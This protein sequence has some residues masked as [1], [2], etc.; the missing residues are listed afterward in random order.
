MELYI[1]NFFNQ[2]H[3]RY[4]PL[5][6]EWVLISPHRTQRPWLGKQESTQTRIAHYEHDC[7]LCPGNVRANGERN[8]SYEST[9]VFQNDFS[10]LIPGTEEGYF[11]IEKFLIA[12]KINGL[13]KVVC[14]SPKHNLTLPEMSVE[15]I[16]GVI[17]LWISE[18]REMFQKFKWVQIFENKG[19]VMGA[20]NP[21]PHCQIWASSFLPNELFEEDKNQEKYYQRNNSV[22]LCDYRDYEIKNQERIV[23]ENENWVSLVPYW[24]VWPYETMILPKKNIKSIM[25]LMEEDVTSLA[26]ILKNHLI[27]YDNLFNI[28]F[29]Y[30][31]GFHF[32]PP[33]FDNSG[34]LLHVH[35]YPPLLR[36]ATIKK[37][38][39][40]YEMLAESQRDI[41]PEQAAAKLK[42]LPEIHYLL[43]S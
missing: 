31:M 25:D 26:S 16:T 41:T 4:N 3:R 22:L 11:E 6:G 13:C 7:Y 30:S 32:A 1:K 8:P 15:E 42:E 14:F 24:A 9:F 5:K 2:P 40:G 39:V 34:W 17:N 29:P 35:F 10:A 36:S 20:S 12:E 37:F 18:S 19:E 33:G 43:N 27:K 38:M 21:H 23:I 28:S